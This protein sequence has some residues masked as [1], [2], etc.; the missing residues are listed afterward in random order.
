VPALRV[1]L[2]MAKY[3]IILT[4]HTT[5]GIASVATE[6]IDGLDEVLAHLDGMIAAIG[7]VNVIEVKIERSP[8][9][10]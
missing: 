9:H 3:K 8:W 2:L 10:G 4:C 1:V 6:E 5:D 7:A